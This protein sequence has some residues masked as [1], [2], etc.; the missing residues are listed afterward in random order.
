[1]DKLRGYNG[2]RHFLERRHAVPQLSSSGHDGGEL[3]AEQ[4]DPRGGM[5]AAGFAGAKVSR[6]LFDEVVLGGFARAR[7]AGAGRAED[8]EAIA[9][10]GLCPA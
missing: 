4:D 5:E 2:L 6:V 9:G 8:C 10:W 7:R 1:M 3:A